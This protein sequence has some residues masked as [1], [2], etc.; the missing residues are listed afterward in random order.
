VGGVPINTN[1]EMMSKVF[2]TGMSAPQASPNANQKSLSFAGVVNK[3]LTD[4]GH[5]VVWGDPSVHMTADSLSGFDSVVVGV[6]P[7][8]SMGANRVYG[9]LHLINILWDS[10]KLSLFVDTPNPSQIEASLRLTETNSASLTKPFFSYRKEYSDVVSDQKLLDSVI[11]GVDKLFNREW[12]TTFFPSLPWKKE[13]KIA[14][15]ARKNLTGLN[16]D[17]YL[18][19]VPAQTVERR[20]KWVADTMSTNWAKSTV[21]TVSLPSSPMKWNKGWDDIQVL[22]QIQRSIGVLISPDKKDGTYWSYRYAQSI[23]TGTPVITDWKESHLLGEAWAVL[24]SSI[25][26][27]SQP[28]R[29]LV[30][31]AQREIYIANIPNK[32]NALKQLE[33]LL[34]RESK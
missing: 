9:A 13:L 2:L 5:E 8:S 25:D 31:T 19:D 34:F 27:M 3:V 12:G 15:N 18:I 32:K 24:A 20:P 21:A 11:G 33:Q 30:A 10:N 26:T 1:K 17:A 29:D 28:K 14:N 23:G 22:D 4:A 16:L 6:S 7:I